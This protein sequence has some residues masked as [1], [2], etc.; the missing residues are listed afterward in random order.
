MIDNELSQPLLR[1]SD[2]ISRLH[3]GANGLVIIATGGGTSAI[4]MLQSVPGASASLLEAQVPYSNLAVD[5]LLGAKPDRY[6]A[7][8]TALDLAVSAYS[9]GRHLAAGQNRPVIGA[10]CTASLVSS[11]P[12]RG[13]H[14]A[15]IAVQTQT[16][17]LLQTLR[18]ERGLRSRHAEE[19]LV[20]EHVVRSL[21]QAADVAD[22]PQIPLTAGDASVFQQQTA[23][24]LLAELW[25]DRISHIWAWPDG[26]FERDRPAASALLCGSFNPLHAAHSELRS[27]SQR[28]LGQAVG[29]ELAITNVDKTP[30]NYISLTERVAQLE[31]EPLLLTNAATFAEKSR[32]LPGTVFVVGY[33]TVAR[34]VQAKYHADSQQQLLSSFDLLRDNQCR[35]LVAGRVS[36]GRFQTLDDVAL[37]P[38]TQDLFQQ[39]P[40]ADFRRDLS[41]T[42]LREHD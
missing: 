8:Q 39:I 34:I 16:R 12:K 26:R 30:L 20:A 41:S 21:A 6:C 10:S 31:N 7:P 11:R 14:R 23:D 33:D 24:P 27:V 13:E 36:S 4:S 37:P 19:C 15:H 28:I 38:G 18:L 22:I 42:A 40:E 29:F 5:E 3:R 25:Q 35:F 17:T 2:V 1:W 9:R 32:F